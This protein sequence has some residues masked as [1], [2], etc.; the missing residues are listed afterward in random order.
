MTVPTIVEESKSTTNMYDTAELNSGPGS[1]AT[2]TVVSDVSGSGLLIDSASIRMQLESLEEDDDNSRKTNL[3]L[4]SCCDVRMA[5][6]IVDCIYLF[7]MVGS[8]IAYFAGYG[9]FMASSVNNNNEE[10]DNAMRDDDLANPTDNIFGPS[11]YLAWDFQLGLGVLFG[12]IGLLG[13]FRFLPWLVLVHATWL[14]ID[15]VLYGVLFNW[16]TAVVVGAYAYPHIALFMALR[17]GTLTRKNYNVTER[18]CCCNR[19]RDDVES[20]R[21]R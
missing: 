5:C 11:D 14:C 19:Y 21:E 16:F 9:V 13:A 6:I 8:L 12:L 4:G 15:T 20:Q 3:C 18:Y 7:S 10:E 17:K 2:H 1:I